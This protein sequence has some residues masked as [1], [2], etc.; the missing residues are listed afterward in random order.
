MYFHFPNYNVDIPQI[1]QITKLAFGSCWNPEFLLAKIFSWISQNFPEIFSQILRTAENL[2]KNAFLHAL[3]KLL[4][5]GRCEIEN[6]Q[7]INKRFVF[8]LW[9]SNILIFCRFSSIAFFAWLKSIRKTGR[10]VTHFSHYPI[11][12]KWSQ[13]FCYLLTFS[14]CFDDDILEVVHHSR[15]SSIQL[16]LTYVLLGTSNN[17]K[18][19]FLRMWTTAF[20]R[21]II[22]SYLHSRCSLQYIIHT[23][24]SQN[25][26]KN[27]RFVLISLYVHE[28]RSSMA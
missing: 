27:V 24:H 22:Y 19:F 18:D 17:F 9:H 20:I 12:Q 2:A 21:S 11:E 4:R 7:L 8:S 14:N 10:H 26:R 25:W 23:I 1:R 6:L 13:F 3:A 5:H 16:G 28:L 15:I